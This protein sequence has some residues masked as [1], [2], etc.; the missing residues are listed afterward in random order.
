[1][2][3]AADPLLV[4]N[5]LSLP[6]DLVVTHFDLRQSLR[7]GR[8]GLDWVADIFLGSTT[9]SKRI[10]G[11]KVA[12]KIFRG[13]HLDRKLL[14]LAIRHICVIA[15]DWS[16]L[17]HPN[18]LPFLGISLDLGPSPA[19]ITPFCQSGSIMKYLTDAPKSPQ[20]RLV[21]VSDIAQG[22]AYLHAERLAHGNLT[23]RKILINSAGVPVI[24]GYGLAHPSGHFS[25]NTLISPSTRFTAPEYFR[26]DPAL[27]PTA[28]DVY[29]FSMVLLEIM[30]GV[31]PYHHLD[32][33]FEVV[34][35][36]TTGGRPSRSDLDPLLMSD[37]LWGFL[38]QLWNDQ[39]AL[40]PD[41]NAVLVALQSLL[42]VVLENP[43]SSGETESDPSAFKS[44][45][46]DD[47]ES[48]EEVSFGDPRL[49]DINSQNLHRC[50]RRTGQYPFDTGGNSNIYRGQWSDKNGFKIR[51]AIKLIRVSNDGSGQLEELLRRL[52]RETEVWSRL[53]HRNVLPFL[54]VWDEPDSPWPALISPLYESGNL[55]RYLSDCPTVDKERL[56][57]GVAS[58][59]EYL[60]RHEIVH[61]DLKVHNVL[62]DKNGTPCICDFGISKVVN[63]QGFTTSSVGTVPYMAPELF[64]VLPE[65]GNEM[66]SSASTS[67]NSDVYSF[68][69]L[70]LEILT[71]NPL[72]N[73]PKHPILTAKALNSLRPKISD[74]DSGSISSSLW[75]LL[76]SCW[77]PDPSLRPTISDFILRMPLDTSDTR[78]IAQFSKI[79]VL[80]PPGQV[81]CDIIQDCEMFTQNR[82]TAGQLANRCH[83]LLLELRE[84][85]NDDENMQEIVHG[86][87]L[88]L[89]TIR[90]KL[91]GCKKQTRISAFLKQQEVASVL[92]S[93]HSVLS[94]CS[95]EFQLNPHLK[96][97]EDIHFISNKAKDL[98]SK[99][100]EIALLLR[101][102]PDFSR[103]LE[104]QSSDIAQLMSMMQKLLGENISR[105]PTLADTEFLPDYQ[106]RS[107][108]VVRVGVFPVWGTAQYDYYK[109]TYHKTETVTIKV[110]RA[111][112]SNEHG[113]RRFRRECKIRKAI[114]EV[115][116]G[117][118]V[119]PF[120]GF[121][122]DGPFPYLV[123]HGLP[124]GTALNYV[125]RH[126]GFDYIRL[127]EGIVS[128]MEVLH[129]MTPP[130]IHGNIRGESIQI[131]AV[132]N[133]QLT[134]FD[135]ARVVEDLNGVLFSQSRGVPDSYR[136]FAPEV[137]IGQGVLSLP[138]DIYAYGMTVLELLTHEHPFKELK[139]TTEVV[140]RSAKGGRPLRPTMPEVVERGLD[141]DLWG[142]LLRCWAHDPS[143]RPT[144]Q[145][146]LS[147]FSLG[148]GRPAVDRQ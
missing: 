141:D 138:A 107:G 13:L 40:R 3:N 106:L 113:L 80:L 32:N 60:H 74:Y 109:G 41:M 10:R 7:V 98:L 117:K 66:I 84:Q 94:L 130:I 39:P 76:D 89:L 119:V 70:V 52:T 62:V 55:R 56:V 131:D 68:G 137:C 44:G 83:R 142:L 14:E 28:G 8:T 103:L 49:S 126:S 118:Y 146:I 9:K 91:D 12:I 114:W 4:S 58:G 133:P 59:L 42:Q 51:V 101:D 2:A 148:D 82:H 120:C 67:M 95:A 1:M 72:K 19:L 73:R 25:K 116:R 112:N 147:R 132:G 85:Y 78:I 18:L 81:L 121:C 11:Q 108:E 5:D 90:G 30:S 21:L 79:P 75:N 6:P 140:M 50:I 36:I 127:I 96:A 57:L 87:T 16:R 77:E 100:E 37:R 105:L 145:D 128:G 122:E 71:T 63:S 135:L 123:T 35:H 46:V 88:C 139:H 20:E 124:D 99:E 110:I 45:G 29:S 143:E 48:D 97:H 54:G 22:L 102:P 93:S 129:T 86:V 47:F 136:W 43:G 115:D 134:G 65:T 27:K 23:T 26:K 69:L 33:E 31:R 15:N 38:P 111:V 53:N 125:K 34:M 92:E 17:E 104:A 64:V 61:G 24:C 144:V